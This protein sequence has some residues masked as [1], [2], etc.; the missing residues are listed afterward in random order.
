MGPLGP[1]FRSINSRRPVLA[2]ESCRTIHTHDH[3]TIGIRC[4]TETVSLS[5]YS[6]RDDQASA[7][8]EQCPKSLAPSHYTVILSEAKNLSFFVNA[9]TAVRPFASLRVT[10]NS[11]V[12]ENASGPTVPFPP[13]KT[14]SSSSPFCNFEPPVPIELNIRRYQLSDHAAVCV[15]HKA[16]LVA[17]GAYSTSAGDPDLNQI[18][19][20]YLNNGGVFLVGTLQNRI[21]AMGALRRTTPDRAE[22]RRMRVHPDFQRH[23]FGQAIFTALE[24]RAPRTRLL[25]PALGHRRRPRRRPTFLRQKRLQGSAPRQTLRPR[26]HFYEKR[27]GSAG[28]L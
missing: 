16:A 19:A 24:K 25:R 20:V 17:A 6:E 15:L 2:I 22:I 27:L 3:T 23:G 11:A 21:I 18:E 14:S 9:S 10:N 7:R 1:V 5:N 26:L 8:F 13:G 4:T 28:S 12:V